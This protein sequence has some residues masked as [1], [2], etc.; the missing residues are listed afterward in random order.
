MPPQKARGIILRKY[1]L[2]ETSY[3]LVVYTREYGKLHGVIKGVRKPYPQFAGDFEIFTLVDLLYYP[4]RKK[5]LDLITRC[6]ALDFFLPARKEIERLTYANYYIELIEIVTVDNDPDPALF[7]LIENALRL[8]ASG[9]SAKRITRIFEIKLL[10]AIGLGPE[11]ENC[12]RCGSAE[13]ELLYFEVPGGAVCREC[14]PSGKNTVKV[15]KGS[16]NFLLKVQKSDISKAALVKVSREVGRQVEVLLRRLIG[17]QIQ[18]PVRSLAFL[19]S[20]E[21]QKVL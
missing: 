11:L 2:R 12:T 8:L 3:I 13:K 15:S 10:T 14:A 21:K 7:D 6:D 18:R 1:E 5:N 17:Y 19:E 9:A 20:I 4:S 16:L